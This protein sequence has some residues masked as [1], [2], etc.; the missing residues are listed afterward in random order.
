MGYKLESAERRESFINVRVRLQR[1]KDAK[2]YAGWVRTFSDTEIVIDF[3]SQDWFESGTKF[4]ITI[5]G[6]QSAAAVQA[7]LDN[8]SPGFITLHFD[9]PLR[10]LN[11][12]E[13]AR[14]QVTGLTGVIR[15]DDTEIEMQ[16]TDVSTKG[17]GAVIDGALP[18]GTVVDIE[19]D[20]QFGNVS[21][22]AEVRYCRQDTKD[23]L[24]HRMGFL[25]VQLGR[26]ETARWSR[27]SEDGAL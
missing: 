1:L 18:R 6:V 13:S 3:P 4:Y 21:G 11:P 17:F 19:V 14:R 22:K 8:Q 2:F 23:S 5:N 26:I 24:K 9:G 7:T 15:L 10:Y 16:V 25:F 27:L 12:S 20:T